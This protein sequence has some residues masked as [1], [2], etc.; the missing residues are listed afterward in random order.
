MS[1]VV[2]IVNSNLIS[3]CGD[4]EG[5]SYKLAV[6]REISTIYVMYNVIDIINITVIYESCQ[7][8]NPEFSLQ[9]KVCFILYLYE[10]MDVHQTPCGHHFMMD[11]SQTI[12]LHTVNFTELYFNYT[13][14][15][16]EEKRKIF[17]DGEFTGEFY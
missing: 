12:S 14:T 3:L 1:S 7:R 11:V 6:T 15:K 8:V 4:E 9:E 13:S 17:S 5:Q 10:I 2:N 16:P